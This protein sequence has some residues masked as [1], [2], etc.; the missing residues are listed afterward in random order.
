MF[1]AAAD[2]HKILC[3]QCGVPIDPNPSNLCVSCLR[4]NVDITEGIPKQV[5]IYFC[6][7]CERYLNPPNQW[8]ACALESREL[9]ALCLK[10]IKNLSKVRLVDAKFL[11]TEPHS[12]RIKVQLSVQAEVTAGTILQQTFVVEYIVGGQ[13]CDDC[14]RVEAK[15]T[16]NASVQVRQKGGQRKTLFYLEQLLI[17]YEATREC[18]AIQP[19]AEGLD[20]FFGSESGARKLVEF[21]SSV[22]PIRSQ[23]AKRLVSHDANSN[24]YNYKYTTSVEI[25]PICKDNVVCLP[26][27]LAQSLGGM[28]R[29]ATVHK[30]NSLV[31]LI[32]PNTGQFAEINANT[33]FKAPFNSL[34]RSS[35]QMSEYTVM[36]I[37]PIAEH[38]RHRFKGQGP[39]SKKHL[40]ADVW[41]VKS[42]ELGA[43]EDNIHCRTH[44]GHLLQV[45]D[46]CLGYDLANSNVNDPHLETLPE[47]SRPDVV[48]VK[49]IFGEKSLRNRRRKWRL[50]HMEGLHGANGVETASQ[51]NDY[52]DFLEDLEEDPELRTNVN[53]Y[54]DPNKATAVDDSELSEED[55]G[56]PRITLA[57][58]L[59]EM[60]IDATGGDGADMVE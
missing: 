38:E 7:F 60:T 44:L 21:L 6:R 57:E 40:L 47:Q 18:S 33:Y 10:R 58:M 54:R 39:V 14:R 1:T 23:H 11:W 46:S 15:D 45:G 27:K 41:V 30:V 32:D 31:H 59:D 50:R 20:F 26:A 9:M 43:A 34:T 51:N 55:D 25:V 4:A 37:E 16:W 53:I 42:S 56:A 17:K 22:V 49:K 13:M 36:N 48:I 5:N 2:T 3:C 35:K 19:N 52:N 12:K 8:V 29:I 28:G 24:T